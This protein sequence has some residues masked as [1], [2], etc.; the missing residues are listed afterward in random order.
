MDWDK[1][2]ERFNK[3]KEERK[4]EQRSAVVNKTEPMS[5][6]I[7]KN[8]TKT[9]KNPVFRRLLTFF[10]KKKKLEKNAIHQYKTNGHTEE[11][12]LDYR[13]V[14]TKK[15]M[16][17]R[18]KRWILGTGSLL[19]LIIIF[20]AMW[21]SPLN[22]IRSIEVVGNKTMTAEAVV[23]ASHLYPN[24]DFW[25][26]KGEQATVKNTLT[27]TFGS[28]R[29]ITLEKGNNHAVIINVQEY[30]TVGYVKKNDFY[31]PVLE[32]QT[33]LSVPTAYVDE[34][35]PLLTDFDDSKALVLSQELAKLPDEV[36]KKISEIVLLKDNHE[37]HIGLKMKDGNIVVGY[38]DTIAERMQYYSQ[39]VTELDGKQGLLDMEAGIYFT[40]LNAS[41]NPFA[42]DEE[43]AEYKEQ[44]EQ[45]SSKQS[46]SISTNTSK[47][48]TSIDS[49]SEQNS[50]T[51]PPPSDQQKSRIE[52]G[53][54]AQ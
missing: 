11:K 38:I 32:N 25:T 36:L 17:P 18:N 47:T 2:Q 31:Y 42:S 41:N 4:K 48:T 10:H 3:R 5:T 22:R 50:A 19:C 54:Q 39:I 12:A 16:T 43:K 23:E 45:M 13:Y 7:E 37:N 30:R 1:E 9:Q 44:N 26:I 52:S 33:I 20:S 53:N 35:V 51:T 14:K 6:T 40:T 27:K 29:N 8:E 21:L 34:N 28:I 15:Q 24:M 46:Q 49:K